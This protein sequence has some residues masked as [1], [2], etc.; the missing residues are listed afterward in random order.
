VCDKC[1]WQKALELMKLLQASGKARWAYDFVRTTMVWVEQHGH[2]T[3]KQLAA[4]QKI[5]QKAGI[6]KRGDYDVPADRA[7]GSRTR[8]GLF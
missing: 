4:V 2:I 7:G 6:K 5:E 3:N 8:S 1:P